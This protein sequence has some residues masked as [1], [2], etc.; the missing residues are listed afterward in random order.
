MVQCKLSLLSCSVSIASNSSLHNSALN[1]A[2]TE[3]GIFRKQEIN[4]FSM[5]SGNLMDCCKILHFVMSRSFS[6]VKLAKFKTVF[7]RLV[8][9]RL[10]FKK[11]FI[12][13]L[14]PANIIIRFLIFGFTLLLMLA[15]GVSTASFPKSR[16]EGEHKL[17][18]L[19]TNKTPPHLS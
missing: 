11:A 12:C 5:P 7:T 18:A 1:R 6:G 15:I 2:I 17:Y 4:S 9:H 19:S 13:S 3:F 10:I 16:S 14:Y 8:R